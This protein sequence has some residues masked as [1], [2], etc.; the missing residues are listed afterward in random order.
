MWQLKVDVT[1]NVSSP[2]N[3]WIDLRVTQLDLHRRQRMLVDVNSSTVHIVTTVAQ[4]L[5]KM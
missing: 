5:Y 1:F 4:V 3:G 2:V